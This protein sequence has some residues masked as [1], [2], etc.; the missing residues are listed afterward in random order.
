M[1][2]AAILRRQRQ[3]SA[4]EERQEELRFARERSLSP[5]C[6]DESG[7]DTSDSDSS[8]NTSIGH[9]AAG[10][11]RRTSLVNRLSFSMG[12]KGKSMARVRAFAALPDAVG[13]GVAM[14]EQSHAQPLSVRISQRTHG[15]FSSLGSSSSGASLSCWR[16][17]RAYAAAAT[18]MCGARSR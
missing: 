6:T 11:G 17:C 15:P 10:R 7:E 14:D 2:A 18:T 5:D 12:I 8:C 1:Q 16:V 3:A 13:A 9:A 4:R